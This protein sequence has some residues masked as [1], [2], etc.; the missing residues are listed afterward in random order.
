MPRNGAT[1][2]VP[3]RITR[4]MAQRLGAQYHRSRYRP[5]NKDR[6]SKIVYPASG[7]QFVITRL[8]GLGTVD[9]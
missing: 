3:P 9:G 5:I 1:R 4:A 8:L 7:V 2:K 6:L